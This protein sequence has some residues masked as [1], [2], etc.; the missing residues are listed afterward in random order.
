MSNVIS[1]KTVM[2]TLKVSQRAMEMKMLNVKWKD[3]AEDENK[4]KEAEKEE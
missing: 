1:N 3:K 2:Q 4:D